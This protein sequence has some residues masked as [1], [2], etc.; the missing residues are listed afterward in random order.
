MSEQL[1]NRTQQHSE[2]EQKDRVRDACTIEK[3]FS[4]E[5]K[6]DNYSRNKES[7]YLWVQ[8]ETIPNFKLLILSMRLEVK[9]YC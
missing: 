3:F 4:Q 9:I 2:Q 8:S 5:T 7:Y 6:D 1:K